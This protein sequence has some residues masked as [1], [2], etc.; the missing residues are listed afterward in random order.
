MQAPRAPNPPLPYL[1]CQYFFWRVSQ[2]GLD[3]SAESLPLAPI[4]LR[5]LLF[6]LAGLF[7]R[8]PP[9]L[10]LP[11]RR[12]LS[13]FS[14]PPR[15]RT[16]TGVRGRWGIR[17]TYPFRAAIAIAA[18][19]VVADETLSLPSRPRATPH[20]RRPLSC[21]SCS[22]LSRRP[23]VLWSVT[24]LLRLVGEGNHERRDTT[25]CILRERFVWVEMHLTNTQK[26]CVAEAWWGSQ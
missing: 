5:L 22:S 2:E 6:L 11:L 1:S 16:K 14:P 10:P 12:R 3:G 21:G 25:V 13:F 7:L 24:V 20:W 4:L 18:K 8:R 19:R 26:R 15:R 9:P 23:V 17:W